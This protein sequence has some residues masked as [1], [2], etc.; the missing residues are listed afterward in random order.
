MS[1]SRQGGWSG[2]SHSGRAWQVLID[3]SVA[4]SISNNETVDLPVA[5]GHHA[6][7]VTSMRFLRSPKVSLEVAEGQVIRLSV[8]SEPVTRS[9]SSDQSSICWP[10]CSSTTSGSVSHLTT[11]S[12]LTL[13]LAATI[14]DCEQ[15]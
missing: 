11:P 15:E 14:A 6:A 9:S 12:R 7:Q 8:G 1:I 4:T 13:K 2:N 3:G 10:A 5:A